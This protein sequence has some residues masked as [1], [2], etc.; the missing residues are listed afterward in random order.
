MLCLFV[1][2]GGIGVINKYRLGIDLGTN[3]LGWA[4]VDLDQDG[5]PCAVRDMGVHIFQDGRNPKDGTSLAVK[6]RV[7]RGMRR[8]RDRYLLRK[9]DLMTALIRHGLMP[10][11]EAERKKLEGLDPYELRVRGLDEA[12][13]SHELGRAL[14]HLHQRRGFR[15]NRKSDAGDEKES[16]K[17]KTAIESLQEQMTAAGARTLGEYLSQRGQQ[18]L[19]RRVRLH[20][21]GA[22]A[23]YD[24]YPQRAMVEAEF[25]RLWDAQTHH[26]PALTDDAQEDLRAVMFRQRELREVKPGKCSLDP[27]QERAPKALP[28]FQQFRIYQE[29]NNL[30]LREFGEHERG[31][32]LEERDTLAALLFKQKEVKFD[33]MRKALK[34][35]PAARFSLESDSRD[36][37][38]GD[39]TAAILGAK[40]TFG[41]RWRELSLNE[42][43]EIVKRLLDVEDEDELTAWLVDRWDLSPEAAVAAAARLPE[44]YGHVCESAMSKIVPILRDQGL[45]WEGAAREAG[46]DP[47]E[48]RPDEILDALP[49]YGKALQRHVAFGTGEPSDSDEK[50]FGRIANPTVHVGLNR[51]RK[52]MNA[53]IG[54]HGHPEEVVIELT[55]DLKR[56]AKQKEEDRKRQAANTQKNDDRRKKLDELRLSVNRENLQRLRFWEEL[57][58]DPMDRCCV[59]TG[60]SI[61]VEALFGGEIEIEHILPFARSLNDGPMNKT[62]SYHGSNRDKGNRSPF[63]AFGHSPVIG[64]VKY[65]WDGIL[66]RAAKLPPAKQKFFAPDAM[67]KWGDEDNFLRRH[68]NE[69][70]YLARISKQYLA[71]ICPAKKVWATPGQLTAMLRGKWGLNSLLSDHNRKDRT[72]HR[73]HAVDALTVALTDRGMLNRVARAADDSRDRLIDDMPLPWDGFRDEA[74][75]HLD[76]LVVS[77]RPDHG[78]QG[79]LHEDTAYGLIRDPSA[80]EG[81]NVVYRKALADLNDN[82]ISRIRDPQLR[83]DVS[84]HVAGAKTNGKSLK[85]ALADFSK[86]SGVRRV[87]LRKKEA[88]LVPIRN[89]VGAVYKAYSTGDNHHIDIFELPDGTWGGEVIT[90]FDANRKGYEPAWIRS[91]PAARRVARVH[92]GDLL[93]LVDDGR[94]DLFRAVRLEPSANRLRLAG[95]RESGD[96]QKRHDDPEDPFRWLFLSF[97]KMKE[98]R[99]RK[100]SVDVLGRV[101][102]PGPPAGM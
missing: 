44:G 79:A 46:Y 32:A 14:F 92:K 64:G 47:S 20:G 21:S 38:N 73:H 94:E 96:L 50:R 6:R 98:R 62:V 8:R 85:D 22:N 60:R 15:S 29:L 57:N 42:Q 54:T 102:D 2:R 4:L 80:E 48:T 88:A 101:R 13:K 40:K 28:L 34:L 71:H 90:V 16:G 99:T 61:P 45:D 69:T 87:R 33:K 52:V 58:D 67:E 10:G 12:L 77:H 18:G 55:R 89:E 100:L 30:R 75:S 24:F 36:R 35:D 17:I 82:E 26:N 56:S 91:C 76:R 63:D 95:H 41:T 51:L 1:K 97:G 11:D 81:F 66:A 19:P 78:I 59:Y 3:S 9:R 27:T 25:D 31:L 43:T 86:T 68:L 84:A 39:Q 49:F 72:D 37:L 83:D 93:K 53:L 23:G 70:G 5:K 65:D 74:Q 7:P